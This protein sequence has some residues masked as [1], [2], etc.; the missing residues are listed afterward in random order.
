MPGEGDYTDTVREDETSTVN[1]DKAKPVRRF[2]WQELSQLN[3]PHN[4][5]V[6]VRGKV[7]DVS[8]FVA[9][10][11]GGM[12]QIMMGAGRDITQVFESYH[13]FSI[14]N[15][16]N[17]FYVGELVDNEMPV[18]LK[19]SEF[20]GVLKERVSKYFKDNNIDPK[21]DYWMFMRYILIFLT[22]NLCWASTM[23]VYES[24]TLLLLAAV[25]WGFFTALVAMTCTHDA[26]HFSVT[27]K[28]WVWKLVA[29]LLN[30]SIGGS[31]IVWTYQ[32]I[33]GHH[34]YT[35][36]DG[37]DPDIVTASNNDIPDIRRIKWEQKWIPRYLYQHVYVPMLY[38]LLVVKT[39]LQ[40]ILILFSGKNGNI[41]MNPLFLN[42]W[43]IFILGKLGHLTCYVVIPAFIIPWPQ[44]LVAILV[45]DVCMSYWLALTFQVSHVV[46]EVEWPKPD[47]DNVVHMDWAEMQ[48][49]T[50]Q[51]YATN[52]WFWTVFTGALNHQTTHHLFPGIIQSHYPKITP[53]LAQTCKEF[54]LPYHCKNSFKE[55]LG[56]HIGH[57]KN[58]GQNS[59]KE[60]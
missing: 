49:A 22:A 20:Y 30:F 38:C 37:A 11:P 9:R 14:Y 43:V 18:F 21:V 55:A 6:A 59:K 24:W 23:F 35:N 25:G 28:P 45:S 33:L 13:P 7:Y 29:S 10:H 48:V 60:Q 31:N 15:M 12:E 41:R 57:L 54:G 8:S 2:T 53:I 19:R 34:I 46:S 47:K 16:L 32:H 50:T 27:H 3:E 51:D 26:S 40:D 4:A 17:K 58:L 56:C 1:G 42:Q 5:H 52:S 39:R 36:I 44:L